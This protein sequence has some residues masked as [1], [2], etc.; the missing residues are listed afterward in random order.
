MRFS[1]KSALTTT[2]VA[3][4]LVAGST[5]SAGS[6]Q[7]ANL[8]GGDFT[9]TGS[10]SSQV[11]GY[12]GPTDTLFNLSFDVTPL[13]IASK[14]GVFSTLTAGPAGIN[15]ALLQLTK[16]VVVPGV[17]IFSYAA[18][19]NF[20]TGLKKDGDHVFLDLNAGFLTGSIINQ[21]KYSFTGELSG[22][23]KDSS[24][25]SI[26]ADGLLSSFINGTGVG[27]NQ[28][29]IT[30]NTVPTPALLPGFLAL[31]AGMLR[32][33]KAEGKKLAGAEA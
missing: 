29:S 31:G 22:F 19:S 20:I 26:V 27:A 11:T 10:M 8:A 3:T 32:K 2:A 17:N 28:S 12:S 23:L 16:S 21:G 25:N 33:R 1:L 30:V 14:T 9:L 7:A 6:V 15:V 13:T 18:T 4:A 24:G 5:F